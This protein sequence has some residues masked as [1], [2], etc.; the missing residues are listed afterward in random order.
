MDWIRVRARTCEEEK[1]LS[2]GKPVELGRSD[3]VGGIGFSPPQLGPLLSMKI[4]GIAGTNKS[5]YGTHKQPNPYAC[6]VSSEMLH[7]VGR[8]HTDEHGNMLTVS[9]ADM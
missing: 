7:I 8:M 2:N 5:G 3:L 1:C 4:L 9:K 6:N